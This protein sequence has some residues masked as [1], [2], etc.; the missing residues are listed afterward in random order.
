MSAPTSEAS[1]L[2]VTGSGPFTLAIGLI[3]AA[4]ILVGGIMHRVAKRDDDPSIVAAP[5]GPFDLMTDLSGTGSA[6]PAG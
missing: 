4:V 1:A 2:P 6:A 5:T 3:G